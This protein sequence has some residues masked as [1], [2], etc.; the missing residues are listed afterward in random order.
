[1]R[2]ST[3]IVK[4]PYKLEDTPI[5]GQISWDMQDSIIL[6]YEHPGLRLYAG[7]Q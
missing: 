2:A 7:D 4:V 5:K 1:M 3:C 6:I